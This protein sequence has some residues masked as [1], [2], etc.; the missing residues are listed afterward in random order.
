MSTSEDYIGAVSNNVN[1]GSSIQVLEHFFGYPSH[2]R[3]KV[4]DA[5]T[6]W[7]A[8]QAWQI[9]IAA[10]RARRDEANLLRRESRD[11]R[12]LWKAELEKPPPTVTVTITIRKRLRWLVKIR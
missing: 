2:L 6:F 9:V 4:E 7:E 1:L 5:N 12:F 10:Y 8:R 3:I 11:L